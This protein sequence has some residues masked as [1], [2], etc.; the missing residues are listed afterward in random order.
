MSTRF[1]CAGTTVATETQRLVDRH[2][3]F[4]FHL[5]T[6][7][8]LLHSTCSLSARPTVCSLHLHVATLARAAVL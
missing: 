5:L 8:L 3:L 6:P 2:L 1:R 4:L 7:A